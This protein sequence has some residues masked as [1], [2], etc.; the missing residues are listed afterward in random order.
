VIYIDL[1]K[2]FDKVHRGKLIK[3]ME[4]NG[5]DPTI[6]KAYDHFCEEMKLKLPSCAQVTTNVGVVQGGVT[7]PT[8]FAI[9]IDP[10]LRALNAVCPTLALADDL[11]CFC[12]GEDTLRELIHTLEKSCNERSFEINKKKSAIMEIRTSKLQAP[13]EGAIRG[14]PFQRTYKY[15]GVHFDDCLR[16]D[17]DIAERKKKQKKLSP[18]LWL[19]RT[20]KLSGKGRLQIWHSLHRSRW[21]YSAEI[22]TSFNY[23]FKL[24]LRQSWYQALKLLIGAKG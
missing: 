11:V 16:F 15:L 2:A 20:Q 6:V 9:M 7:S 17:V 19:L 24:W 1:R 13:R 5:F 22:M 10:M 23:K 8:S 18:Q 4:F 12:R 3:T 14:Y 21:S